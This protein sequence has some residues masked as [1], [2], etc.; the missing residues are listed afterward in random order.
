MAGRAMSVEEILEVV[1]KDRIFY[2]DSGGGVTFSGGEPL[3]QA[4]FLRAVLEA[5]RQSGL[6]TVVDSCGL[7]SQEDLLSVAELTDLFLFDVKMM[8]DEKHRRYTGVSNR[9]IL[10]NLEALGR[11]EQPIWLRVPVIPG[12][13]DDAENLGATAKLAASI[14][15][16]E[17]VCLLPY[18]PLGESKSRRLERDATLPELQSP[19]PGDMQNLVELVEAE[20]IAASIGG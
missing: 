9:Q 14:P 8:N 4:G 19:T 18:H 10:S 13:N 11:M 7:A 17:R 5:C 15:S 16:V 3:R 2:D 6:H 12:L 1:L 20:G